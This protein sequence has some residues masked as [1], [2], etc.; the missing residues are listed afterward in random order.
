MNR[1]ERARGAIL[2]VLAGDALGVPVEGM[3]RDEFEPVTAMRGGGSHLQPAGTFSDD[4]S[5][6]LCTVESLVE[7]KAFDANDVGDRLVRFYFNRHW[8]ARHV[9]FGVGFTT[10]EAIIRL[11]D[12]KLA[13]QSG[14]DDEDSNGNGPLTRMAPVVLFAHARGLSAKETTELAHVACKIT[15]AHPRAQLVSGFYSLIA[16]ALLDG[17]SV[18][19][20]LA[21]MRAQA[22]ELYNSE[23]W[24]DE[25][26]H[27]Q[28]LMERNPR[29]IDRHDV[30][31]S[32]YCVDTLEAAL[33]C[34]A[35][36][37]PLHDTVLEAVNLGED[38]DSV[39]SVV[40]GLCGMI[41]GATAVPDDW[42]LTIAR[43]EEVE[44]LIAK[45]G[46]FLA[47]PI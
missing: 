17:R 35:R 19:D 30:K 47:N 39:G 13:S 27:V 12:G 26:R 45:F 38:S 24:H 8:T 28:N 9:M 23:P 40:G 36:E 43:I 7:K 14:L 46:A 21:Y 33:W 44:A 6:T 15:H 11:R 42:R 34:L 25:Y 18:A 29:N 3:G 4:G 31:S 2:G 16:R 5:M 20:A 1:A 32:G 37:K 10:R 41:H 22:V